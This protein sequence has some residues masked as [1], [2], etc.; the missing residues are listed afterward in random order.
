MDL[1][2]VGGDAHS[3]CLKLESF[4]SAWIGKKSSLTPVALFISQKNQRC[5][6]IL[7]DDYHF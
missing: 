7:F 2:L 1:R 4:Y 3:L 5:K 6:N